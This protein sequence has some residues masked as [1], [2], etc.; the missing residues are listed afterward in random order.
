MFEQCR[1][2]TVIVVSN[3]RS[4]LSCVFEQCRLRTVIVVSNVMVEMVSEWGAAITSNEHG[5]DTPEYQ[6]GVFQACWF[7]G[8][9]VVNTFFW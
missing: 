6:A 4:S 8:V 5:K 7:G 9:E 1:L 2:R 3:V